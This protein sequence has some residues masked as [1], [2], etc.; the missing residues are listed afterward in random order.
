MDK[1]M[2]SHL[3]V[4]AWRSVPVPDA[5]EA[6]AAARA[7]RWAAV[8]AALEGTSWCVPV[9][10]THHEVGVGGEWIPHYDKYG[11]CVVTAPPCRDD[12]F[13]AQTQVGD[14]P[15]WGD[16]STYVRICRR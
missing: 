16:T 7:R 15:L 14:D 9:R 13:D 8:E 3:V 1:Y 4:R 6:R 10:R 5:G 12:E 11:L 2:A